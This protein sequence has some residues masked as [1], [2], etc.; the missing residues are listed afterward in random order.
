[1]TNRKYIELSNERHLTYL[2]GPFFR[3]DMPIQ[4]VSA[5]VR[6]PAPLNRTLDHS[7]MGSNGSNAFYG[8]VLTNRPNTTILEHYFL[9][10]K[11]SH[12][13]HSGIARYGKPWHVE[14]VLSTCSRI[15]IH[16]RPCSHKPLYTVYIKMT[17][18]QHKLSFGGNS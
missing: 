3:R 2:L 7:E 13:G 15:G 18:S 16:L 1:V 11:I 4:S 14:L 9:L 17:I 8:L 5:P 10:R 12:H 6:P